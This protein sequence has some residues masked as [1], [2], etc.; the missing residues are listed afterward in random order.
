MKPSI[1]IILCGIII[2]CKTTEP[3]G[4]V[5]SHATSLVGDARTA[6]AE[7]TKASQRSSEHIR[8]FKSDVERVEAKDEVIRQWEARQAI[9]HHAP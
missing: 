7:S 6:A 9:K 8:V 4:R 5:T 3:Q 2:G 1:L